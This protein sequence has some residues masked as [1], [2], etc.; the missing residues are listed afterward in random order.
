MFN[1]LLLLSLGDLQ[2][3]QTKRFPVNHIAPDYLEHEQLLKLTFPVLIQHTQHDA[4]RLT[5]CWA[6]P[7]PA[8][9]C[10][11]ICMGDTETVLS[12]ALHSKL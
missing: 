12:S 6:A 5:C 8:L 9:A 7:S 2:S 4:G 3:Q 11:A 1:I 10:F